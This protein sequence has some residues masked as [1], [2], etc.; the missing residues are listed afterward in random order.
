M[1][2]PSRNENLPGSVQTLDMISLDGVERLPA[3]FGE[4]VRRTPNRIAYRQFE[5]RDGSWHDH[6][7]REMAE[8]I[9]RWCRGFAGSGLVP[10]DRVSVLLKN[11]VEWVCFDQAALRLGL[12][13]VPL[14]IT[15]GAHNWADQLAD[16]APRLL[17]IGSLED[18]KK[19]APLRAEFPA[20]ERIVC[21]ENPAEPAT[22]I[23]SLDQWLEAGTTPENVAV[24]PGSLA[25]IT[26]TSGTTGRPKGVMLSHRNIVAAAWATMQRNPVYLE[27]VFLSFLP[28]AHIF[29]RT[30]EYY[31]AIAG[32]GQLA[33]ARS[34]A[35][36][37]EDFA[38][39]RPTVVMAVPRI[40]ERIWKGV[41]VSAA[42]NPFGR[43]L[44]DR[45]VKI[46]PDVAKDGF[47]EKCVRWL[48]AHLITRGLLRR[49]G[50]RL[51]IT[52]CG[53]A[54][55]SADLA[56]AL[57]T[58]GLPLVEGYGLAEAAG[59][60]S[61]DRLDAYVP[62]AVGEPLPGVTIRISDDD[63]ILV[64]SA[65]VMQ[66][67]W[68]RPEETAETVT[69]DGWLHTGDKG[70]LRQGRL[71][72]HGRLRDFIVLSNGEKFAPSDLESRIVTD[73]LFE[74]AM[75]IGDRRPI[76][77]ALVIL[78][79]ERWRAF[80]IDQ[81]LDSADPNDPACEQAL[82]ARIANLCHAFPDFAQ[83]RRVHAGFEQWTSEAGL[84]SVTL[85]VKREAVS[86]RYAA[87]IERLFA[88]H[89]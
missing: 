5:K 87:E 57:R 52:V 77:V 40:F 79:G 64:R 10:G 89:E 43:W 14:H 55:L 32:G 31:L 42:K 6:S 29:E 7:W 1:L 25:T 8:R 45:A 60:V 13:T 73:P 88:G 48:V 24:T 54:P 66:G 3:L 30:T 35:E 63:E 34:I 46:G 41:V 68:N 11:S 38:T 9:D 53:G 58:I 37:P 26:Y 74:Q 85:K 80:A 19:L 28:M 50:G 16:A 47:P 22:D 27:D 4:R 81:N 84:L 56:T 82:R 39:V 51:R 49:F 69:A 61:G 17:L 86:A 83:V 67:Y 62:G 70:E 12:V 78:N 15:D 75:V 76:A 21:L 36:L 72:I 59:P 71:Y 23:F 44:L 20:L 2:S 33:F 18:W 65:S